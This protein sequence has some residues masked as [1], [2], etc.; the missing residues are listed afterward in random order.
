MHA[1]DPA[2]HV[3]ERRGKP[4]ENEPGIDAGAQQGDL[5]ALRDS[6]EPLGDLRVPEPRIRQLLTRG[7]DG[8][9]GGER[10]R[11]LALDA[12]QAAA[13]RVQEHGALRLLQCRRG[14]GSNRDL[15]SGSIDDVGQ[16]APDALRIEVDGCHDFQLGLGEHG[17]GDQSP[18][19]A[20]PHQHDLRRQ[21][22]S[23]ECARQARPLDGL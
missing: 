15:R 13:G 18:D 4:I 9:A 17:A 12:V 5:P 6:I 1:V 2:D 21:R 16:L 19:G 3:A 20:E 22:Q 8:E 10:L 23:S 14:I 11:Q 7:D